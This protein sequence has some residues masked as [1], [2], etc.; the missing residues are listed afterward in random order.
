MK[1]LLALLALLFAIA[2][3][4]EESLQDALHRYADQA[5]WTK[6][7][8][9]PT[10]TRA[11]LIRSIELARAYFLNQQK[12]EGN[13]VYALD[14]LEGD[15]GGK[16]NSIR[17]SGALWALACLCRDRFNE[18]TRRAVFLG[19][20]FHARTV[21]DLPTAGLKCTVYP[22]F[23]DIS[24]G[25]V[26]LQALAI[27]EFLRGQEPYMDDQVKSNFRQ[28]LDLLIRYLQNMEQPDGSWARGYA[29]STGV[30]DL[31]SSPYYDGE[32]LLCYVKA[33]RYMGYSQLLPRIR[34]AI[35]RLLQ[36]YTIQCW[37]KTFDDAPTKGFYQ[38]ASMAFAEY[39]EAGWKEHASLIH[40]AT[41]ALAWWM[42]YEND[43]EHRVGN[44][45]YALEGLV[46]AW[47]VATLSGEK[48][49]AEQ[50]KSV[51]LRVL[52]NLMP[53]QYKG[54]YMKYNPLL[55]SLPK[56]PDNAIG[57][58]VSSRQDSIVRIDIHQHQTHAMLMVLQYMMPK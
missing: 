2:A 7:H 35:P 23:K 13:F 17:Q 34:A 14:L 43:I 39:L 22:G 37:E 18:P 19:I 36:K 48:E 52:T 1:H 26:A 15:V 55:S 44:T 32:A 16:D 4:A 21:K 5:Q 28:F 25:A 8:E 57:G 31:E 54:P 11:D 45:G 38:W 33:A 58:I 50:L 40:D 29:V 10:L 27:L 3:H 47:Q 56:V 49:I 46:G 9:L 6:R 20:D 42:I 24:T 41:L 51:I 30:R 53:L 12:P